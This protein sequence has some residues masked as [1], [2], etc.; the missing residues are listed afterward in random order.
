MYASAYASAKISNELLDFFEEKLI[1][2]LKNILPIDGLFLSMMGATVSEK[3]D[4]VEDYLL[5][6]IKR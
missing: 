5:K 1:F 3:K 6:I 4:D 2:G